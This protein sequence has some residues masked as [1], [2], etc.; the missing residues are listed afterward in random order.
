MNRLAMN[1]LIVLARA[2][3][4]AAIVVLC[5]AIAITA[6]RW[7]VLSEAPGAKTW[8]GLVVL[9]TFVIF[10]LIHVHDITKE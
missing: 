7:S 1:R 10:A 3:I 4:I 8:S 2:I 9:T 6:Y 5:A